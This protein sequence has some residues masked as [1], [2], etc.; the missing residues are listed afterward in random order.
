MRQLKLPLAARAMTSS[1]LMAEGSG[2]A[3]SACYDDAVIP[4]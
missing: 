1:P 2:V 3:G 4:L